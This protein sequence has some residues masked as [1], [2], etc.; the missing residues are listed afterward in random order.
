VAA[1]LGLW[2]ALA[3]RSSGTGA[4]ADFAGVGV[5]LLFGVSAYLLHEWGHLL[6]ALA[7]RSTVRAAQSLRAAFIFQFD[8]DENSLGQFLFM[9]F[10]GF[11]ATAVVVWAF[12]VFLP[13][14]L[15]ATRVARGASLVLAFTGLVLEFPLVL[16]ALRNRSIPKV[17]AVPIHGEAASASGVGADAG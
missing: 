4:Q 14:G 12:Y 11:A 10:S 8:P 5:G 3:E 7:S 9:S 6:A 16:I 1:A 2:W 17:A 15:L 13:D